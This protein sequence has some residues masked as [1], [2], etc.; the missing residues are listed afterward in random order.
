[1]T[2]TRRNAVRWNG[3]RI[4]QEMGCQPGSLVGWRL[5]GE[6]SVTSRET[7]L[8]LVIDQALTN[9]IRHEG[10]LPKGLLVIDEAHE[11]SVS[12][13]LLLGLIKEALPQSP[14]TRVLVTSATIDTK[15][16]SDF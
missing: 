14:N 6:N 8:T 11:R 10:R 1:M 15:K 7:R 13:D 16:F 5:F 12:T 4:A 2:Q 9:R 3:K